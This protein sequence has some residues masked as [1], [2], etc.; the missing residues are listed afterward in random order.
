VNFIFTSGSL[1]RT[2]IE[3]WC[4]LL[5]SY[6]IFPYSYHMFMFRYFLKIQQILGR[7]SNTTLRILSVP[8]F[9]IFVQAHFFCCKILASQA[10]SAPRKCFL[11]YLH[12][13]VYL[14]L[15][16]HL[17]KLLKCFCCICIWICICICFCICICIWRN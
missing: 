12:L 4:H 9:Y 17:H 3:S 14:Y 1:S 5:I 7:T 6:I 8:V 11:L 13:C 16:L 10:I 2:N 15:Y